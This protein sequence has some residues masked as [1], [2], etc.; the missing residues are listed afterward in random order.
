MLE[1]SKTPF[2]PGKGTYCEHLHACMAQQ[3]QIIEGAYKKDAQA[4]GDVSD[5]ILE[6]LAGNFCMRNL[7]EKLIVLGDSTQ[8]SEAKIEAFDMADNLIVVR[9]NHPTSN[10]L[11]EQAN[12][13]IEGIA[14]L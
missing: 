5:T 10:P 7:V 14:E 3:K 12:M 2:C 13:V 11:V 4:N 1:I 6:L 8:D 9:S